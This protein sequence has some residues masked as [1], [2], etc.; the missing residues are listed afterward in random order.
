MLQPGAMCNG[1][2]QVSYRM[3]KKLFLFFSLFFVGA[4]LYHFI[5]IFHKINDAPVWRHTLFVIINLFCV[6]GLLKRPWYFLYF[7]FLFMLQQFNGHGRKALALL[8]EGQAIDWVGMCEMPILLAIFILL[9]LDKC[10][11][12]KAERPAQ[13][14][15]EKNDASATIR[16]KDR[17]NSTDDFR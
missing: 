7:F 5:G 10:D 17:S 15:P 9:I 16:L 11:K 2:W 13:S 3:D 6:Y 14:L 1:M 4:A 8:A 12:K